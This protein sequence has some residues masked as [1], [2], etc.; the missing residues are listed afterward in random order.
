MERLL[1]FATNNWALFLALAVTLFFLA[2]SF[3]AAR[4][5]G[6]EELSPQDAT[7]LINRDDARVVDIREPGEFKSGH[8]VGAVNI[9]LGSLK[10]RMYELEKD[11]SRPLIVSC[12]TGSRS[13]AACVMLHKAGFEKVSHLVG[14][15][16]RWQGANLPLT[17]K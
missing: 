13:H 14:G 11:K 3:L 7:L 9:P 5:G 2:R 1:E 16:N 10:D 12:A 17:T 15:V 4:L 6:Y 8:I